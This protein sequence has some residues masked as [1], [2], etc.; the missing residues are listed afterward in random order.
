MTGI[1]VIILIINLGFSCH[2]NK[3]LVDLENEVHYGTYPSD[4]FPDDPR[5]D[6]SGI[7]VCG[8]RIGGEY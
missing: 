1:E 7:E 2:L 6:D 5:L 3:K 8:W 4:A